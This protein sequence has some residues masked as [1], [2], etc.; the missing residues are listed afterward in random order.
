MGLADP[1]QRRLLD[2]GHVEDALR[3]FQASTEYYPDAWSVYDNYGEACLK[4]GKRDLAIKNYERA[5]ILDP[6]KESSRK[7]LEQLKAGDKK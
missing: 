7:A 4:A 3:L 5:L 6:S 2:E 1:W